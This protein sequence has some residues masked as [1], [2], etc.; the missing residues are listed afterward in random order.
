[1]PAHRAGP[2]PTRVVDSGYGIAPDNLERLFV[3][4]E[5]LGAGQTGI[6]GSGMGLALSKGLIE[7]MGGAIGVESELDVGTT[8]WVE[9]DVVEGA[10]EAY[11]RMQ[12]IQPWR[13][14]RLREA[15]SDPVRRG[16]PVQPTLVER[17]LGHRPNIELLTAMQG[18]LGI[19][20]VREHRPDLV[21]LDLHLPD[22]P[23]RDVLR[24]LRTTRDARDP[25]RRRVG[26]CDE[27]RRSTG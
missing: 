22:I 12:P 2:P 8:F 23:G 1:M 16:Q 20:L 3:P 21:L 13:H 17:I 26:R 24:R 18:R 27:T 9:L 7:A 4:F 19:E 15:E 10:L 25:G 14:R 6:E 11:A 5:R